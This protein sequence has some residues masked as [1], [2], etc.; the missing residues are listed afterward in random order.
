MTEFEFVRVI[1]QFDRLV[2][3]AALHAPARVLD[4]V[5]KM[6]RQIRVSRAYTRT[7]YLVGLAGGTG[8]GKSSLLNALA[9]DEVSAVGAFRPT[10]AKPLAWVPAAEAVRLEQLW[11]QIGLDEVVVHRQAR[12]VV[13]IDLP[14]L[15]SIDPAHREQVDD[16]LP[17]LDL[18]LWVVDPEK[19]RDRVLHEGYVRPLAAHQRR[20]RFIL[21]Q[22]DRLGSS[23]VDEISR[24][25]AAALRHDGLSDP[26]VWATAADPPIGPP[27]GVEELWAEI[28]SAMKEFDDGRERA[29]TEIQRGMR[30]LQPLVTPVGLAGKWERAKADAVRLFSIRRANEAWRTLRGLLQ[31]LSAI[32]PEIDA[33]LDVSELVGVVQGSSIDIARQL[34]GSLGRY[35]RDAL[36]PRATTGALLTELSLALSSLP[37]RTG[38]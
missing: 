9:G 16:F 8:S 38:D 3:A 17:Y 28:E 19:Y 1:D 24:D 30:E 20:F 15:D 36:R 18:V 2:A 12:N 6:A 21:N 37:R 34:E 29:V 7:S 33:S 13:L 11:E 32:A 10:T 23:E 27:L 14:D 31:D 22:I 25:F 4:R 26:I 5:A 35:L